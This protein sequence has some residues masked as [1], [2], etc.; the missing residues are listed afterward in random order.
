MK[1]KW[2]VLK[3]T[4]PLNGNAQL[5][6]LWL[7]NMPHL[8]VHF[9]Q[10]SVEI[11]RAFKAKG[12]TKDKLEDMEYHLLFACPHGAMTFTG[13]LWPNRWPKSQSAKWKIRITSFLRSLLLYCRLSGLVTAHCQ[14]WVLFDIFSK[15]EIFT[16]CW[17]QVF[18]NFFSK[19]SHLKTISWKLMK[20]T[21]NS[22]KYPKSL[23][24]Q[25][26]C[27]KILSH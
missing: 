7:L 27:Q 11:G 22:H 25:R 19:C 3:W 26:I 1:V 16:L 24:A 17:K 20:P 8:W 12:I 10:V 15:S 6:G 14:S 2:K 4:F 23:Y 18:E 13:S 5:I 21:G 9:R